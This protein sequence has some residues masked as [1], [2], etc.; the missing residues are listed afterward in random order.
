M[1]GRSFRA[2]RLYLTAWLKDRAETRSYRAYV[3]DALYLTGQNKAQGERWVDV[4]SRSLYQAQADKRTG[5]QIARDTIQST[6]L[7]VIDDA[8]LFEE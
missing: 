6:G 5:L 2:F 4:I 8:G 1:G 7:N 3:T